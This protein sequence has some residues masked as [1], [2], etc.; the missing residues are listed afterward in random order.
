MQRLYTKNI[1]NGSKIPVIPPLL[2][3]DTF[4]S[5][6]KEKANRFNK[7]F[8]RHCL[9][10]NKGSECPGQTIFVTN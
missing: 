10:L 3:D 4:A 2:I 9:P 7:F 1:F 5:D 8:S 6:F